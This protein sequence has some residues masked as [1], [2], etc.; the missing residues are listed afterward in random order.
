M[1]HA[2]GPIGFQRMTDFAGRQIARGVAL[3]V[4]ALTAY[5]ADLRPTMT[6][7]DRPESC[8]RLDSL[9]LLRIADQHDLGARLGSTGHHALELA[10]ADHARLVDDE[11]LVRFEQITALF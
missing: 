8:A 4:F 9:Q 5:F 1:H 11:H 7:M 2:I 10:C 3:P 6:L